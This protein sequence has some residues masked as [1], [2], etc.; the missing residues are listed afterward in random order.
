MVGE[1]EMEKCSAK[2]IE[3][4]EIVAEIMVANLIICW[5]FLAKI[6]AMAHGTI[7]KAVTKKIPVT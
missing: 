6:L 1:I 3:I 7:I 4:V 2:I 5:G